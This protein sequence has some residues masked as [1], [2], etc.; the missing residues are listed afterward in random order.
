MSYDMKAIVFPA[1]GEVE[2]RSFEL[3]PCGADEIVVKTLYSMVSTGT[4]LRVWAGHYGSES[5]FPF[6]PGYSVI[7][8]VLEVGAEVTSVA[9]GDV[10]SGRNPLPVPGINQ[11]WG[12]QAS[13]HRYQL[14]GYD[15]ALKLPT[16][17]AEAFPYLIC[18]IGAIPWR[19]VKFAT[20]NPGES[21]LVMGQGLIGA[22]AGKFLVM[23]DV[24]TVVADVHPL[25]LNR[26][27]GWGVAAAVDM[28]AADANEQLRA[29]LPEGADVLVEASGQ[30]APALNAL[31][32]VRNR[33]VAGPGPLPRVVFQANYLDPL[34]LDLAH[35]LPSGS[36]SLFYPGDREPQDRL[37][38]IE[39]VRQGRISAEEF[40]G[41]IVPFTEAPAAYRA[42][43]DQ[44]DQ[45]FSVAFKWE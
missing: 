9:V 4:E 19:G 16:T 21:A 40:A 15:A 35:N 32:F 41:E 1:A 44:P 5:K 33:N 3:P 7:G 24:R 27:L 10:V 22:L 38:V 20:T 18:E 37:D 28:R 6:I 26:A 39:F 14:G 2:I 11:Y 45:H 17:A 31:Q 43:R 29:L 36:I 34:N 8:E 30:P 23:H 25:R 13:H 42:L 12:A